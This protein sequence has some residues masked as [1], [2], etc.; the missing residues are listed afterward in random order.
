MFPPE[1]IKLLIEESVGSFYTR[2]QIL[3]SEEEKNQIW[4]YLSIY[5]EALLEANTELNLVG[6]STIREFWKRHILDSIQLVRYFDND[7]NLIDF[8]TGNGMPGIPLAIATKNLTLLLDKSPKKI[9]FVKEVCNKFNLSNLYPIVGD[10]FVNYFPN[11]SHILP[12]FNI[13]PSVIFCMKSRR[14]IIVSRAF[15]KIKIICDTVKALNIPHAEII[16]LKGETYKE[17]LDELSSF[18]QYRLEIFPSLTGE[19]VVIRLFDIA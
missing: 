12:G 17:E 13:T 8:G 5:V 19:G 7:I 16:V 2:N 9:E 15:K 18:Y 11:T 1:D 4:L 6:K 14:N 10:L 3:L